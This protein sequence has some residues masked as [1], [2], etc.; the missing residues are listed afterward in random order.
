MNEEDHK[1][2]HWS[3]GVGLWQLDPFTATL[4]LNHAERADT[5]KGGIPTAKYLLDQYCAGEN[6]LKQELDGKW[7]GC[8]REMPNRCF[9][10]Y[11]NEL[12]DR[13]ND[14]INAT[15][16]DSYGEVDGG[17][18]E[19]VCRWNSDNREMPCYLVDEIT[20]EGWM[21]KADPDDQMKDGRTPLPQ[22]FISLTDPETRTRYAVWPKRWP[23]SSLHMMWPTDVV[24][25]DKTIYRAAKQDEEARCSP[26]LDPTPEKEGDSDYVRFGQ[27]CAEGTYKPFGAEISN[28]DFS[29]GR[30]IVEGWYD[31]SVPYRNGG[32]EA[33]RHKLQVQTCAVLTVGGTAA[34]A[35]WWDDV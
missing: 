8:R 25:T 18:E 2:A 28:E 19:R 22:A 21:D 32:T 34:L 17:I 5:I 26:G 4:N 35:C 20:A 15:P 14:R 1:R 6:R 24:A 12:Y 3:P 9:N 11:R 13:G 10:T 7:H 27:D 16:I 30:K 33:D 29:N 31:D 23:Y